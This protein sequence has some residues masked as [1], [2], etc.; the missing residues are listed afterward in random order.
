MEPYPTTAGTCTTSPASHSIS[1]AALQLVRTTSHS[2]TAL[3]A[4]APP[5]GARP[6]PRDARRTVRATGRSGSREPA[7]ASH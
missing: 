7:R 6:A 1:G 2:A 4:I 3:R 5:R